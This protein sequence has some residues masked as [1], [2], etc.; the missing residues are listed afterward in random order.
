MITSCRG[1]GIEFETGGYTP[2]ALKTL[3][4][5][6]AFKP[7]LHHSFTSMNSPSSSL[8][9]FSRG[10]LPNWK[11]PE[12]RLGSE[13]EG[14]EKIFFGS[15]NTGKAVAPSS[16]PLPNTAHICRRGLNRHP[17]R[18]SLYLQFSWSERKSCHFST[19]NSGAL[20]SFNSAAAV[21]RGKFH[22]K[23]GEP[24]DKRLSLSASRP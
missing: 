11:K 7:L 15:L 6:P 2:K 22:R 13:R 4:S 9:E 16:W 8:P 3:T 18:V 20:F 12:Q 17:A 14:R 21:Q 19:P 1:K 23:S 24:R 10:R 5:S